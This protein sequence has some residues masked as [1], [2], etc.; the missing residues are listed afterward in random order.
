MDHDG[1][2]TAFEERLVRHCAPTLAG[3]KPA[4]LFV[5]RGC[6]RPT[7]GVPRDRTRRC[8]AC[9]LSSE[10]GIER[11]RRRLSCHGVSISVLA[12]RRTGSLTYV[13]RPCLLARELERPDVAE[14]LESLGYAVGSLDAC[15]ERLASR[16]RSREEDR[17]LCA[18]DSFPHEI[19]FFLGYPSEDVFAFI[20]NEGK[21]GLCTG[22]WKVYG[23]ERS[24]K[25]TF[26]RYKDCERKLYGLYEQGA[27]LEE[28]AMLAAS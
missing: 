11:C 21:G 4:N 9:P 20:E 14:Y 25:E 18:W 22:C 28:L 27:S 17:G 15:V 1:S 5:F 6:A 26:C 8:P 12:G 13:Y 3:I 7:A 23:Q 2:E 10:A 24:A 19:G 16:V